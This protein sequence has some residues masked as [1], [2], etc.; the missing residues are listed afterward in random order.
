MAD[1]HG[2]SR[3]GWIGVDLDGVLAEYTTWKGADHIGAPIVAMVARMCKWHAA[4]QTVKVMTARVSPNKADSAKCR[5]YIVLWCQEHLGFVPEIT[6]EKDH[7]M[8][9]LWDDRVVQM[10]PNTGLRIDEKLQTRVAELERERDEALAK[11]AELEALLAL[12]TAGIKEALS[13]TSVAD[14]R[15]PLIGCMMRR[16]PLTDEDRKWAEEAIAKLKDGA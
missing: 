12:R 8:V 9:A 11:V 3:K 15:V 14:M 2:D 7:L 4:G 5:E 10:E 13:T 1:T 16:L 6:H